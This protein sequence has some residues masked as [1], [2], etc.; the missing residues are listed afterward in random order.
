MC[1]L[2]LKWDVML[3]HCVLPKIGGKNCVF[4]VVLIICDILF[5]V[6]TCSAADGDAAQLIILSSHHV[7]PS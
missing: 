2:L 5:A 7:A 6:L 3:E 1:R 4:I